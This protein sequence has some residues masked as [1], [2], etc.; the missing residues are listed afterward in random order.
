MENV[1]MQLLICISELN[2]PRKIYEYVQM[3]SVCLQCGGAVCVGHVLNVCKTC[4]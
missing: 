4:A 1:Y 2:T 3:I